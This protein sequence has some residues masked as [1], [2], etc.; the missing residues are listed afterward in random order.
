[1]IKPFPIVLKRLY[2][3]FH[4]YFVYPLK[5]TRRDNRRLS[6]HPEGV[7]QTEAATVINFLTKKRKFH[8]YLEIGIERGF[9]L[10]AVQIRDRIGVDPFPLFNVG[11]ARKFMAIHELESD[12]YFINLKEIK[13]FDFIYLDGL[14][15]Y[16]QTRRD[17]ENSIKLINE[18]GFIMIDDT[19][20]IDEFSANPDQTECYRMRSAAGLTNDGSW[21]G[22]V[23]KLVSALALSAKSG[24]K[25]ATL[26]DLEN[27]KTIFWM[28]DGIPWMEDFPSNSTPP[29]YS[30]VF[31][32]YNHK[33][34]G[35]PKIFNPVSVEE[36]VDQ[37]SRK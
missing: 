10:E 3:A 22:D 5:R 17:F 4:H 13:K 24:L 27:P 12:D 34:L 30:D 11:N 18:D 20:P 7:I 36:F 23:F 14:H 1:M 15:T 35:I 19:V 28:A 31:T 25:W 8:R 16:E 29:G 6:P 21:H 2:G 32:I 9:T 37:V 26:S 33:T